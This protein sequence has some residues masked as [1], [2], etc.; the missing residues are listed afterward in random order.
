[1]LAS[2]LFALSQGSRMPEGQERCHWCTGPATKSF[3]HD[4]PKPLPFTKQRTTAKHPSGQ[5]VCHGCWLFRRGS[6]TVRF[7]GSSNLKDRQ[8]ARDWA[9]W[10][11]GS[12]AWAI[13]PKVDYA[14]L[15]KKLLFPPRE[16]CLMLGDN[17]AGIHLAEANS[18]GEVTAGTVFRFT[19]DLKPLEF[20]LYELR[21]AL[22]AAGSN[23]YGPGVQHILRTL[24]P[25]PE[26]LVEKERPKEPVKEGRGRPR[27]P[28]ESAGAVLGKVVA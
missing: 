14:E 11:E 18:Y 19:H 28:K 22:K 26:G 12:G 17:S 5:F 20:S 24:G 21:E 23:G 9:W 25:C 10:I 15:W 2:E 13:R 7:L 6:V 3:R 16:W 1:M 27:G 4:D 8:R